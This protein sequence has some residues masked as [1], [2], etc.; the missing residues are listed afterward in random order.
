MK[1]KNFI[2]GSDSNIL[3]L[4]VL[5]KRGDKV[6][7]YVDYRKLNK[8]TIQNPY[9]IPNMD[10]LRDTGDAKIFTALDLKMVYHQIR[11]RLQNQYKTAFTTRYGEFEYTRMPFRFI[12][13]PYTFQ[14]R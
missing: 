9:A 12:N 1:E 5:I 4:L 3:S 10:E 14:K 13:A 11:R 7:V 6:C 8:M 2:R